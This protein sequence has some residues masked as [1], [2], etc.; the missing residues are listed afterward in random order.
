MI[1]NRTALAIIGKMED[2]LDYAEYVKAC[3]EAGIE[4]LNEI[5]YARKIGPLGVAIKSY[6]K[7]DVRASY[8]RLMRG[9]TK[10][11]KGIV[12][13]GRGCCDDPGVI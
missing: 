12:G 6:G 10:R 9:G 5:A 13:T 1:S 7:K 3:E 4:P 11:V 2:P 8:F